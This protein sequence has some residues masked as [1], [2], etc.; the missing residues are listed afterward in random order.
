MKSSNN[1]FFCDKVII[2][3]NGNKVIGVTNDKSKLV[4]VG[5]VYYEKSG[6]LEEKSEKQL[7]IKV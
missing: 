3:V 5:S 1:E 2:I 7:T 4:R 6:V